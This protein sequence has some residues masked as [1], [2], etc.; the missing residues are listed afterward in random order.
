MTK[1][2]I[3]DPCYILEADD[4]DA[5]FKAATVG[6]EFNQ[7][8]FNRVVQKQLELQSGSRAWVEITGY[9][10]WTNIM[11]GPEGKVLQSEFTADSGMVCV[12]KLNRDIEDA[13]HKKIPVSLVGCVA[14]IQ[15]DGDI[16]VEMDRT[17]KSWTVVRIDT[18]DGEFTSTAPDD[19]YNEIN[20]SF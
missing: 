10:D 2:I 14:I 11:S 9:G 17:N 4:W 16:S 3:T 7:E 18:L 5:C 12:C 13:L 1:Y 19:D 15:S 20:G 6:K 8:A